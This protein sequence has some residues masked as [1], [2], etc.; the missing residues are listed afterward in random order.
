M[1]W[2]GFSWNF[3][4][5]VQFWA[6]VFLQWRSKC[7][8][9]RA[10]TCISSA[11]FTRA[12][13]LGETMAVPFGLPQSITAPQLFAVS[14]TA[15][16]IC[17]SIFQTELD[18]HIPLT[19]P[20]IGAALRSAAPTGDVPGLHN[21][22]HPSHLYLSSRWVISSVHKFQHHSRAALP[23]T[24]TQQPQPPGWGLRFT[25]APFALL[26]PKAYTTITNVP[27]LLIDSEPDGVWLLLISNATHP[28]NTSHLTVVW[29]RKP[30]FSISIIKIMP[31]DF[32]V[33]SLQGI[34]DS[35]ES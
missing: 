19:L 21:S 27:P 3:A 8:L 17:W 32:K 26:L 12:N 5:L 31:P 4:H 34:K 7:L 15:N 25:A 20:A 28:C 24:P 22:W 14:H 2:T 30:F 29:T 6:L 16:F 33:I 13:L 9:P 11:L 23:A 35:K 18:L 10:G 1:G